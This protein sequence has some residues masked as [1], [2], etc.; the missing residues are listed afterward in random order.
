MTTENGPL[1]KFY[2][3]LQRNKQI[4]GSGLGVYLG[5]GVVEHLLPGWVHGVP[6]CQESL[7]SHIHHLSGSS[8]H[9]HSSLISQSSLLGLLLGLREGGRDRQTD[10]S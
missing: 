5:S 3:D 9:G 8:M 6:V 10:S 2:Y 1:D 7:L 4:P